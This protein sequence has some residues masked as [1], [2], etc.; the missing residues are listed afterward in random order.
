MSNKHFE[1]RIEHLPIPFRVQQREAL[2]FKTKE[3]T[4]EPDL[5]ALLQNERFRT[6]LDK[7]GKAGWELVAVQAVCRG[8][9]NVG[10]PNMQAWAYGF[11]MP[12]GYL[13]FLKREF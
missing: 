6:E 9:I 12:I 11:P 8:E 3:S 10:N 13:L 5:P 1:H 2:M 4:L 7:L